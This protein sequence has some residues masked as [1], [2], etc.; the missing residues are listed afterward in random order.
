MASRWL[1]VCCVMFACRNEPAPKPIELRATFESQEFLGTYDV[2]IDVPAGYAA[3]RS[4]ENM[5]WLEA[6]AEPTL[7]VGVD[8]LARGNATRAPCD[9]LLPWRS[10]PHA[11][12][13]RIEL[14]DGHVAI[15]DETD[16]PGALVVRYVRKG[17]SRLYCAAKLEDR[18]TKQANRIVEICK[19]MTVHGPHI[20]DV[21]PEVWDEATIE[22]RDT[23]KQ[24]HAKLKIPIGYVKNGDAWSVSWHVPH[25]IRA[26]PSISLS[27]MARTASSK[28]VP[29]G[30]M[31]KTMDDVTSA[32][33]IVDL[34]PVSAMCVVRVR[35][36][37]ESQIEQ[38][39][40][41]CSSMTAELKN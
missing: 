5:A 3:A 23:G 9:I 16:E 36:S 19:T 26:W 14:E 25:S 28:P 20:D 11:E 41:V 38:L 22:D 35:G 31:M 32:A 17:K 1:V 27:L 7:L 37:L 21:H 34:G 18:S 4:S 10:V 24:A 8:T 15:C 2:R 39:K 30:F 29:E 13:W 12:R 40:G 6:P 33:R